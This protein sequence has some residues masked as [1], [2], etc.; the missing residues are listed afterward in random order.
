MSGGQV[1]ELI[2]IYTKNEQSKC[3]CL[4][5]CLKTDKIKVLGF[6]SK[7]EQL[8][9]FSSIRLKLEMRGRI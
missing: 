7:P 1:N 8:G 5:A 9:L 2:Y 3:V 4:V 6:A